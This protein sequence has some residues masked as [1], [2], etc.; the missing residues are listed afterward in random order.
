MEGEAQ[1]P[2]R[3]GQEG[4][5]GGRGFGR[6]GDRGGRGGD[7]GGRGGRGFIKPPKKKTHV[8]DTPATK[9]N[10]FDFRLCKARARGDFQQIDSGH[11]QPCA[12][13]RGF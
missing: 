13:E 1:A 8:S 4:G 2:A 11:H 3:E 12:D 7:R 10:I 5:R 6:G 9:N